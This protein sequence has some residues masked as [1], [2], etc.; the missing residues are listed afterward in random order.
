V[1]LA[2]SHEVIARKGAGET[3]LR[4]ATIPVNQGKKFLGLLAGWKSAN[5][6]IGGIVFGC[7]GG[8]TL[9]IPQLAV[10]GTVGYLQMRSC[11]PS[12]Y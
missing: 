3:Q 8:F 6:T 5:V 9:R 12:S 10:A 1:K 11:L 2:G 7:I 4:M